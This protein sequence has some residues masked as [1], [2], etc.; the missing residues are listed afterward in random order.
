MYFYD[1]G[2]KKSVDNLGEKY[3]DFLLTTNKQASGKAFS[4]V[5]DGQIAHDQITRLLNKTNTF[6]SVSLWQYTKPLCREASA[7]DNVIIFDDSL[8]AKPDTK[9]NEVVMYHYDHSQNRFIK[10]ICIIT[11]LY[12]TALLDIPVIVEAVQRQGDKKTNKHEKF[13]S[14]LEQCVNNNLTFRYVLADTWYGSIK[15]MAFI[16]E[17]CKK[18]FI[19][20]LKSNRRVKL[21]GS[22]FYSAIAD[23]ELEAGRV[24][25]AQLKGFE[26]PIYLARYEVKNGNDNPS[27][28][29]LV[30]SDGN[31]DWNS[32]LTC[33]QKRWQVELFHRSVK[34]N[35]AIGKA[36]LR[37]AK[38]LMSHCYAA[39]QAFIKMELLRIKHSLAHDSLKELIRYVSNQASYAALQKLSTVQDIAYVQ[40]NLFA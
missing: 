2:R 18:D 12:H 35:A 7:E 25:A 30:T 40:L 39:I 4:R 17:K 11:A 27:V 8:V 32:M 15:N 38:A 16:T 34:Q 23:L 36:P 9:E 6:S 29:Y 31:L 13:C 37:T 26:K 22:H 14:M 19:F 1:M 33:Y 5:F 21:A 10:G 28:L 20:P 3:V 24:Y